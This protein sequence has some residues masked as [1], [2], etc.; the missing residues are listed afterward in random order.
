MYENTVAELYISF[1]SLFYRPRLE[2]FD[3]LEE[4]IELWSE[5]ISIPVSKI[6]ELNKFCSDYPAGESRLNAL[7]EHYIPLF[8][9][10][11]VEAPPYASVYFSNEGLVMGK[12]AFAVKDSYQEAGYGMG[13]NADN[14]PD[15]LAVELEFASLLARDGEEERLETFRQRHL[16]PFLRMI[17]PRIQ[18]TGR[19]V[20]AVVAEILESWQ[21][22]LKKE[23]DIVG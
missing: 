15:H 18:E 21:L 3:H 19:P 12:E 10:G 2:I 9:T 5:E 1:A 22:N 17:L 20:Y 23:G 8:E 7:W 13:E 6:E 16:L 11:A 14:L 4:L